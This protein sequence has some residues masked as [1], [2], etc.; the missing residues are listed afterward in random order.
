MEKLY[1]ALFNKFDE[2]GT[3]ENYMTICDTSNKARHFGELHTGY[4]RGANDTVVSAFGESEQS[5]L[6]FLVEKLSDGNIGHRETATHILGGMARQFASQ[7]YNANTVRFIVDTLRD[8]STVE[9]EGSVNTRIGYELLHLPEGLT[10][11]KDEDKQQVDLFS[12]LDKYAGLNT[13]PN[14]DSDKYVSL[15][16]KDLDQKR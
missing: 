13:T 14:K 3:F 15:N 12:Y 7:H 8:R 5:G 10:P 4:S 16:L 9:P 2:G 11:I 1:E 6:D